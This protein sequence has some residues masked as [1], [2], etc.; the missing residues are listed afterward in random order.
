MSALTDRA[1]EIKV[2]V[3]LEDYLR[4]ER[5]LTLKPEGN[6][7]KMLCTF[8]SDV[9]PSLQVDAK[10]IGTAWYCHGCG[11]GGDIIS[12]VREADGLSFGEA[13]DVL[14]NLAGLKP[15][16]LSDDERRLYDER[17]RH[18]SVLHKVNS[19]FLDFTMKQAGKHLKEF[20]EYWE[21]KRGLSLDLARQYRV[22]YIDD[23]A[24]TVRRALI[25]AGCTVQEIDESMLLA[26]DRMFQKRII[27]GVVNHKQ[28]RQ[29][30]GRS[31]IDAE[32]KHLYQKGTDKHL[33]NL[34]R[35]VPSDKIIAVESI[36]DALAMIQLGFEHETVGVMGARL[37]EGQLADL[38]RTG[39][40]VWFL[41]DSDKAG[42][43][44]A[45]DAGL[46]LGGH[47]AI[48]RL[49]G[50]AKDPNEFVILGG[51]KSEIDQVIEESKG[52]GSHKLMVT[53]IDPGTP[54]HELP[55]ALDPILQYLAQNDDEIGARSILDRDIR[56]HF[57]MAAG[58]LTPYRTRLG[59]LREKVKR[60]REAA[61]R[62]ARSDAPDLPDE[63][64]DV[65]ELHNGI[66]YVRGLLWFQFLIQKS[67]K[68]TD[69]KTHIEKMVKVT[70]IWYICSDRGTRARDAVKIEDELVINN[71]PVGIRLDRWQTARSV[72]NSV[73]A[74][75]T[76]KETVDPVAT[77]TQIRSLLSEY[78]WFKDEVR[79]SY[80]DLLTCWVFMTYW[81]PVFDTIGYLFL[82]ASPRSGKTTTMTILA[83]LAYEAELMGDVSGSALFRKIE[84]SKG[85]MLLDEMEKLASEEFARSGDPINQ[86]LLTGY[87]STGNTQRTDLDTKTD[88][89]TGVQTFS[90]FGPKVLAN[91]QGIKVQTIR[92]RS[93]ELEL[94][95]S[96]HKLPQFNE[97]K[98]EKA[99]TFKQLRNELYCIALKYV[100]DIADIYEDTLDS[101]YDKEIEQRGLFGRDYEVWSALWTVAIWLDSKGAK[102]NNESIMEGL[103]ELATVHKVSRDT[104]T[105]EDS[106]DAPLLKALRRFVRE[107]KNTIAQQTFKGEKEWYPKQAVLDYLRQYPRFTK[108][109]DSRLMEIMRRVNVFPGG[110][111]ITTVGGKAVQVI[112]VTEQKVMEAIKRYDIGDDDILMRDESL[113]EFDGIQQDE[114]HQK[115]ADR[116]S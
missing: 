74:W 7:F 58:E 112:K 22:G 80:Y 110:Q 71:T 40:K 51:V 98:H 35:T 24:L 59:K 28:V 105:A 69:P 2:A 12:Y 85:A 20:K 32:P 49:K 10:G 78:L 39:K 102:P 106:I 91:T 29:I 108:V 5:N 4:N 56:E 34:D 79:E 70:E 17:V 15:L 8:H 45:I 21:G 25:D 16:K 90:T 19:A 57:K 38:R 75:R 93:I 94:L 33:F 3:P 115:L 104:T 100:D 76:A 31:T 63:A 111:N 55:K 9:R 61:D 48:A 97:R 37:T 96:D 67:E 26:D 68:M 6:G 86:V 114:Q 14:S 77:Y 107:H 72:D 52:N 81:T 50:K 41:F 60:E 44:S 13:I 27:I 65:A 113:E 89:N 1:A 95:R 83:H 46:R 116:F 42:L 43:E 64:T 92:D 54:R 87:K 36:L 62:A 47:H 18:H 11:K 23:S 84:G 66:S 82:H 88:S 101:T 103:M 73:E 99:G 53:A 30:Y 109:S